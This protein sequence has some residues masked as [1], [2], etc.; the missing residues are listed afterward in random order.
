M[1]VPLTL[2]LRGDFGSTRG[3]RIAV[4]DELL[5]AMKAAGNVRFMNGAAVAAHTRSLNLP[6]EADPAAAHAETLA[7]VVFRG[8]LAIKPL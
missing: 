5:T 8:D 3:A 6:G 2:H 4:L 1:L 7:N